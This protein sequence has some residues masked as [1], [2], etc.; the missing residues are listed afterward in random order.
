MSSN[1][2]AARSEAWI[3]YD[4]EC[5]FCTNYVGLY[6]MRAQ[7]GNVHLVN[8]HDDVPIVSEIRARGIDL[9]K[10]MVLKFADKF[11]HGDKCMHMLALLSSESNLVNKINKWI[12][13][14]QERARLLYPI[15]VTGRNLTLRLL[16]RGKI[17][18]A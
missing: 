8:A 10:G 14:H 4:G 17:K 5:P 1:E 2:S 11:Y 9:N 7:L 3:V 18:Q 16:G 12:F 15:L 6:R 13:S